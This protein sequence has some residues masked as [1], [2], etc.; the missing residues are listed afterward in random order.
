MKKKLI[1]AVLAATLACSLAATPA[2]ADVILVDKTAETV[3]SAEAAEA[4]SAIEWADLEA[5]IRENSLSGQIIAESISGIEAVNYDDMAENLRDQLNALATAEW[6]MLEYGL[7]ATTVANTYDTLRD[8]FDDLMDG[9]IQEDYADAAWQLRDSANQLVAAGQTLYITLLSLEQSAA[10]VERGIATIDRSLTE[11]NLRRSLGQVSDQTVTALEQTRATT[12]SSLET[13]NTNIATYKAQLQTLIG[14][15]PTGDLTL[16]ALPTDDTT[17]WSAIDYD[18][19]LAAAK[20]VSWTLRDA[21]VTLDDAAEDWDDAQDDYRVN[22]INEYLRVQAEHTWNAAQITWQSAYQSF[23]TSFKTLYDALADCEQVYQSKLDTLEYQ[24]TLL[25]TAETQYS[26]GS[27]SLSSVRDAEDSVA[28]AE[29]DVYSAW[30]D[31]FSA[32]LAYQNAVQ[33]GIV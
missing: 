23:E 4:V 13:L 1:S 9:K 16:G 12:V 27:V 15:E 20:A 11:M 33:Y 2:M 25:A 19:D 14:A 32:R 28:S 3:E 8:T 17:D 18:A 24:K 30:L 22:S 21:D 29:S 5:S 26:Y 6:Y 31:L 10:D 7:D